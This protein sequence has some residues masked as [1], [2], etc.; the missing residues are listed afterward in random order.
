MVANAQVILHIIAISVQSFKYYSDFFLSS[1]SSA[2]SSFDRRM[3]ISDV[4]V[5]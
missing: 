2:S 1:R 5:T 4:Y 3:V